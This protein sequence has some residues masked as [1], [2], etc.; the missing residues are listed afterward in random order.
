M[1]WISVA[2]ASHFPIQ[3]IPFGV[4]SM[5]NHALPSTHCASAIGDFVVDLY[6]LAEAG[7]MEDLGCSSTVFMEP[8]LNAFMATEC[9]CWKATRSRLKD[10]LSTSSGDARLE[11]NNNLKAKALIPMDDVQMHLP[12]KIGDYTDFYS[13]RDH[14]TNVGIMIRGKDNALQPN[15]LHLPVGYHGRASSVVV[16]G[17]DVA[18]PSGQLQVDKA[19]PSKGS[20]HGPCRLMDFELEMAIFLGGPSNPTGTA[21]N[22]ENADDRIF[23]AVIMNDWSARDVQTWEYVPLGPFTSK[24]FATSISPWCISIDALKEFACASSSGDVQ[25]SREGDPTPLPYITDPSYAKGLYDVELEVTLQGA[26]D[27]KPSTISRSNLKHMYWNF[28]QQLVHHSVTGCPMNAGD[29]LGTGTI[30]GPDEK[31]LGCM[32][33]LSWR[34]SRDVVL[35][36][37]NPKVEGSGVRKFLK[38]GDVV[39][40]LGY[41]QGNGYRIGFGECKGKV[42]PAG[43]P[44]AVFPPLAPT[45]TASSKSYTLYSYWRSTCS[46][47]VRV[48][49][50][51]K[52]LKYEYKAVD[53]SKLVGNT[54]PMSNLEGNNGLPEKNLMSQVPYLH[55]DDKREG[56]SGFGLTQSLAIIQY[57]EDAHPTGPS[58]YPKDPMLK[59]RANELAEIIN[60]GMQPL[61]NL[62][63]LRSVT[64]ATTIG[65]DVVVDGKGFAKAAIERGFTAIENLISSYATTS[66]VPSPFAAGTA[67]PSIADVCLVPQVYNAARFSVDMTAFPHISRV[68]AAC[69][70]LPTFVAA[71]PENQP[72]AQ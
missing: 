5:K 60:S 53:L 23:G 69:K 21:I 12:A 67:T 54:T 72:D 64:A 68:V 4:F 38:D 11:G 57:L 20:S 62:G 61:Q 28:R 27:D 36:E 10:L 9:T 47:R 6:V 48:V 17:T 70:D 51:M 33:E 7:L 18:R 8:T 40:M 22:M 2:P 66:D 41:A 13:S 55:V 39:N 19:D 16:S 71:A 3:N 25:G 49:M 24:N 59:A 26:Q 63:V 46:W 14:A 45:L 50:A 32:L 35:S 37:G 65:S 30:S 52:G 34:G 42:L 44:T 58:V 29:L 1:S 56:T 43:T 31:S 15:W